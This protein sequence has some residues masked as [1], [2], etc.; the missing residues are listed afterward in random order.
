MIFYGD[1]YNRTEGKRGWRIARQ[2]HEI[3]NN[4]SIDHNGCR[5]NEFE[6]I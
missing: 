3:V 2:G 5:S 4:G 6:K 1:Y